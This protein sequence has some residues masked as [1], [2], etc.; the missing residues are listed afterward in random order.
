M[1]FA[2][3]SC[4]VG[5]MTDHSDE[6][7]VGSWSSLQVRGC[8]YLGRRLLVSRIQSHAV[9]GGQRVVAGT[10]A[11]ATGVQGDTVCNTDKSW[12]HDAARCS[13]LPAMKL[14]SA[15]ALQTSSMPHS[16]AHSTVAR[17]HL[18]SCQKWSAWPPRKGCS[19]CTATSALAEGPPARRPPTFVLSSPSTDNLRPGH[20]LQGCNVS[21]VIIQQAGGSP[22]TRPLP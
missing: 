15:A 3:R 5:A 21:R 11:P 6:Q 22:G 7:Q 13:A 10:K 1:V 2:S 17:P 19:C 12:G 20:N 14:T 9:V 4:G 18:T 16:T 8:L